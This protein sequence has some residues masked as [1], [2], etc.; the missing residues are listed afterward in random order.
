[1]DQDLFTLLFQKTITSI[2]AIGSLFYSTID[3]V[4]AAFDPVS[5]IPEGRQV[6]V[7][8]RLI[9]C[10]SE[11]LDRI[12]HS[13]QQIDIYFR[14]ELLEKGPRDVP[15]HTEEFYH[16]VQYYPLDDE[17]SVYKSSTNEYLDHLD[18]AQAKENLAQIN[19]YP[20]STGRR[21]AS[22]KQYTFRVTAWMDKIQVQGMEEPLNLMFYWSSLKP[23]RESEIFNRK[24]IQQ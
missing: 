21:I 7:S 11:D 8:T 5:L 23:T 9:N 22:G 20:V 15:V 4:N 2:I 18:L 24:W 14:I 13:G 6:Y 10:Y 1:M 16:S 12:F 19:G 3:G 17:F